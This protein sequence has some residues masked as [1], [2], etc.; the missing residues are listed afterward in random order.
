MNIAKEVA[1]LSHCT[2]HKVGA[3]VELYG[4]IVSFGYNGTPAG[5]QNGCEDSKG[6]THF[7][8][9]HAE[10][11][12]LI[13]AAKSG[14]STKGGTLYLTLSPCLD[15]CKIILQSE[16]KRVVYLEEYRDITGIDFL[17]KFI[18]IEKHEQ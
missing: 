11:N 13:K 7:Y 6:N 12:A 14:Q 3:V 18:E 16:I 15:C 8:V 2:R 4:N 9:L 17:S 10:S 1:T 5:M